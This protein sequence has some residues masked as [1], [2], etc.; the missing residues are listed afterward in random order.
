M[1]FDLN[2]IT[3]Q[4]ILIDTIISFDEEYLRVSEIKKLDNAHVS[5]RIYYSLTKEVI[6]AGN[7]NGNMTLVDGYSG[8]LIDY[9]FNIDLDEILAD[10]SNE[11]EKMGKKPQ[12]SLDL[13]E[14]L[15]ENIVLEVPIVVSKDNKVKTKKGEFWEVRDENSKKDDPRLECFRT[16]LDEGKE[17][18]YG[19]SI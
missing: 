18:N 4:G 9:P 19:S 8:D 5:G 16:L 14:V 2:K 11:D 10:F 7:V 1:E 6:F 17:W 3:E 12:N 15:W 13:K